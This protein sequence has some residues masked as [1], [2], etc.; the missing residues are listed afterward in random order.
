MGVPPVRIHF[1]HHPAIGVFT[2]RGADAGRFIRN[3]TGLYRLRTRD[4]AWADVEWCG[5]ETWFWT[6][7][8]T[9]NN[10][11]H[12]VALCCTRS[13]FFVATHTDDTDHI[14]HPCCS[15]DSD[16]GPGG[17]MNVSGM[18]GV[19]RA[20][21]NGEPLFELPSGPCWHL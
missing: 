17:V 12:Y 7:W 5:C 13:L 8:I 1:F 19:G 4:S 11:L 10:M 3:F 16:V 21:R 6:C 15:K 2:H 14:T 9:M 20:W 18:L